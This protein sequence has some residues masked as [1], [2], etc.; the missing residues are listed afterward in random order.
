[1]SWVAAVFPLIEFLRIPVSRAI[2]QSE[3]FESR[4]KAQDFVLLFL[5][6][7]LLAVS[8]N[9]NLDMSVVFLFSLLAAALILAMI[10]WGFAIL[11]KF[12][13]HSRSFV[14]KHS[15]LNLVRKP[16]RTQLLLVSLG[17]G[18]FLLQTLFWVSLSLRKQ[19]DVANR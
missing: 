5:L 2:Q 16:S 14:L 11:L 12:A 10:A 6:S 4:L 15:Y 17:L 19:L 1:V 3:S 7:L 18:L 8:V 9:R 13:Q